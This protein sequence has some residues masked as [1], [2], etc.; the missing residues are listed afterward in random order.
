VRFSE[1]IDQ[2]M[3]RL[4]FDP[5][6]SGGLLIALASD[7]VDGLLG[8]LTSEGIQACDIGDVVAEHPGEIEVVK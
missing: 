4:L 5:Q 2:P 7:A 3:Q 8:A 1:S 6:T